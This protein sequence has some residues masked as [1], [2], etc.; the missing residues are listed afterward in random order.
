MS[1]YWPPPRHLTEG[2]ISMR[3]AVAAE[4]VFLFV[5]L[6]TLL[7]LIPNVVPGIPLLWLVAVYCVF[8]LKRDGDFDIAALW[9]WRGLR[10]ELPAIAA[11][12][13]A[14]T[15]IIGLLVRHYRPAAL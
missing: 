10:G 12:F 7:A 5:V 4:C 3:S 1:E 2:A 6:P 8:T 14:A 9:K 15:L 11:L 13:G